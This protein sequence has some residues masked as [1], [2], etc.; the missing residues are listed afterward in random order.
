MTL[1]HEAVTKAL[2]VLSIV[3]HAEEEQS[4]LPQLRKACE[5]LVRSAVSD[6]QTAQDLMP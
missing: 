2:I 6:T 4:G 5:P 3:V 1:R